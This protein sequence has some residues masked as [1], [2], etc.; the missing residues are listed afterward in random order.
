VPYSQAIGLAVSTDG[1]VTFE[2]AFDGP[3]VDRTRDEPYFA[4]GPFVLRAPGGW[5]MW[6]AST[7]AWVEVDGALEP[8]YAIKVAHSDDGVSWRRGAE[9]C[10]VPR[11]PE[12]ANGRP[13]VIRDER[14][15][16]MW[17]S[18]R[19]IRG[20]RDDPAQSYRIGYAVS[21][22]GVAWVRRDEDAGI[23][24]SDEGW[25]SE[26]V[27]YAALYRAGDRLHMLY[28]GNGFG[29][30]GVGHAVEAAEPATRGG[31]N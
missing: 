23:T 12:E 14:G 11:S 4:T 9:T 20:F 5:R 19:S 1:G 16:R 24:V 7:T 28:N 21:E 8:V 31:R 10:I 6:Y 29:A 17:Y 13:W 25:D 27:A 2:R 15:Y 18:Y 3:I 22:D 30:T 26:M